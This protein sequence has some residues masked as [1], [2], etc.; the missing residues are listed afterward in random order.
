MNLGIAIPRAAS[1]DTTWTTVHIACAALLRGHTV[2]FIEPWDFEVDVHGTLTARAHAFDPPGI[3]AA[4]LVHHLHRRTATR[5][6]L[7]IDSLDV[8]LIRAAPFDPSLLAFAS[9]AKERGVSVVNDPEGLMRVSHKAW[10]A[11]L[12]DVATPPSLVTQSPGTA[13]LFYDKYRKPVIVKPARGS[14]GREVHFVKRHD[15]RA[16]ETAF[17]RARGRGGHVVVQ[18]YLEEAEAGEKRV[19]WMDGDVLGGYLRQRAP[20]EFRHNLKQGGTAV[21]T[22][23]TTPERAVIDALSPHL[24]GAGIRLAGIDMI[25]SYVIE[26]NALNP[27]GAY[28]ADRL[29][30]SDI[31]GSIIERLEGAGLRAG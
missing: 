16:F 24:L 15:T 2:R 1:L 22:E 26:V 25:G 12:P 10:L 5:R 18:V 8:L 7:R 23:I 21:P 13:A 3:S 19:V 27:G 31:S 17:A 11:G 6:Y 20:G 28:H 30:G 4:E 9:M 29:H 14:G